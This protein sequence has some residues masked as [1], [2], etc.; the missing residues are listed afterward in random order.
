MLVTLFRGI[1][2]HAHNMSGAGK[3]RVIVSVT[4]VVFLISLCSCTTSQS[5]SPVD[6]VTA[7]ASSVCTVT[8]TATPA[9][10]AVYGQPDFNTSTLYSTGPN[11]LKNAGYLTADRDGSIYV[12][13]Y[14]NSRV[15]YFPPIDGKSVNLRASRVYGQSDFTANAVHS[16]P[17]GLNY[18]HGVALA[19]NGDL[20]IADMFNNRV[21]HYPATSTT[22]DRVYGQPDFTTT[23]DNNG[24][25]N[26]NALHQPQGLVVDATGLYVAD[27]ANN[28]VLHYPAGSTVADFVYGQGMPGNDATNFTTNQSG[29]GA[30]GL[31]NPRDVAIDSSGLYVADAGNNRVVH[32]TRGKPVADFVYGQRDFSLAATQPNRGQQHPT[33]TTLYNP[34]KVTSDQQGGLYVADRSNNRILYYPPLTGRGKS[35]LPAVRLYGQN[36]FATNDS[37]TTASTFNAPGAVAVDGAGD[38]FV[39]DIFNQ[40]IL[41]FVTGS[42][43]VCH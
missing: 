20:Y 26:A 39:L 29:S 19:G 17:A 36:S 25:L 2:G 30:T 11:T 15:L 4:M 13:D 24:G 33:A 42:Y 8:A 31:N 32:Y 23:G 43:Y 21:L 41:K 12:A 6:T 34:T 9:A 22:A 27:S 16:G 18:P 37:S 10:Q 35:G 5:N 38:V 40:R 3:M 28:R 1:D 7:T 14:G